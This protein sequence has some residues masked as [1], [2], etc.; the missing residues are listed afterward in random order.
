M[1]DSTMEQ[2]ANRDM[3][4][5]H[6]TRRHRAEKHSVKKHSYLSL[7]L[8]AGLLCLTLGSSCCYSGVLARYTTSATSSDTARVAKFLITEET[9]PGTS[10]HVGID[11][12]DI[13]PGAGAQK[14]AILAVTNKSEVAVEYTITVNKETENL[15]VKISFTD[16]S[17]R[18]KNDELSFTTQLPP[19]AEPKRYQLSLE[20]ESNEDDW[21]YMGMVDYISITAQAVQ[22][23]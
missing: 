16:T 13:A 5:K 18:E 4:K 7:R 15:P 14:V 19:G 2:H 3:T 8:A 17:T 22:I 21:K 23:D 11:A 12:V 1:K 10:F 9:K 6:R 20:W